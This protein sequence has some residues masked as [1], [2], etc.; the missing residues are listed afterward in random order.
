[1]QHLQ[2]NFV[3]Q[4]TKCLAFIMG[5][6]MAWPAFAAKPDPLLD[7]GPTTPCAAAPD[8]AGNVDVNGNPVVPADVD[9]QP[10]PVP[11]SLMVPLPGNARGRGAGRNSAY[12]GLDGRKLDALVNPPAC[13]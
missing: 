7:G 4:G 3:R 8:Y 6:A 5:F 11:D 10:V 13:H 12:A 1:M 2:F 9:A